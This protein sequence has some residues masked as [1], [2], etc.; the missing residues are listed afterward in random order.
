MDCTPC[1]ST[2]AAGMQQCLICA[3][4][5][6]LKRNKLQHCMLGKSCS[7]N[8]EKHFS[9]L[10]SVWCRKG[11]E[12][13]L[14]SF[15]FTLFLSVLVRNT[16]I[17]RAVYWTTDLS[18]Y[19][20]FFL[21]DFFFLVFYFIFYKIFLVRTMLVALWFRYFKQL[22]NQKS[23]ISA[24]VSLCVKEWSWA[25]VFEYLGLCLIMDY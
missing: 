12:G 10:S 18:F 19:I 17:V 4:L 11:R 5:R 16:V 25:V 24:E 1:H 21:V 22:I 14:L 2:P 9:F 20:Y 8:D 6:V 23:I 15:A 7:S 13:I 3:C